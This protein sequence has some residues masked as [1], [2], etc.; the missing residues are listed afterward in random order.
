MESIQNYL[1]RGKRVE[2][3]EVALESNNFGLALLLSTFCDPETYHHATKQFADKVLRCG[4]PL[5]TIVML[6]S[7]QLDSSLWSDSSSELLTTWRHHLAAIVS[8]RT[9]GWDRVLFTLGTKLQKLGDIHAAHVCFMVC[10]LQVMSPLLPE[11]YLSLLG[12]DHLL[13]ENISLMTKEGIEAYERTEA[14]EWAKRRGNTSAL[15][16]TLQPFKLQ[17]AMLLA[18]LGFVDLAKNYLKSI[19]DVCDF[20]WDDSIFKAKATARLTLPEMC[21]S[22]DGFKAALAYFEQR[23]HQTILE[24][25]ENKLPASKSEQEGGTPDGQS[26]FRT[27]AEVASPIQSPLQAFSPSPA[28]DNNIPGVSTALTSETDMTFLTAVT[29][30][31]QDTSLLDRSAQPSSKMSKDKVVAKVNTARIKRNHNKKDPLASA[32]KVEKAAPKS[33]PAAAQTVSVPPTQANAPPTMSSPGDSKPKES[34]PGASG[35]L[36]KKPNPAPKSLPVSEF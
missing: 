30:N 3:V 11:A 12:C 10:G 25:E 21:E 6:F 9:Q 33:G 36:T 32:A 35:S 23:L 4:S 5:H 15:I 18:D 22:P 16:K 1:L 28:D 14:Y 29:S 31:Q 17:Y 24:T 20:G 34:K 13:P 19:L 26:V 8:N 27:Q 7:G 2:A